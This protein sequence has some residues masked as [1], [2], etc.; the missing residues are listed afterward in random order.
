M[1]IISWD[2][3]LETKHPKIDEQHKALIQAFNDLH[4]AMK[5]GKG[6]DEVGRTL[7]FLKDYT[8]THFK[9]E[10][11]L[12]A[13]SAYPLAQR[14]QERHRDFVKKA[15]DLVD[16]FNNGT[17]LITLPVMTFIEGWLVEHIQGEDFRLAEFL[18]GKA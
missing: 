14:H 8:V 16:Q 12:M 13:Q 1:A 7:T 9:M 3:R 17:T 5:Q 15:E 2:A 10:E 18:R 11:E 4:V 6:K